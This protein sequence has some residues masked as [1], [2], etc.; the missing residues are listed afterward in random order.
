M[1]SWLGPASGSTSHYTVT[2]THWDEG[3]KV[4]SFTVDASSTRFIDDNVQAGVGYTY[5]V[6]SH[7]RQPVESSGGGDD[8]P[9]GAF[10]PAGTLPGP[11]GNDPPDIQPRCRLLHKHNLWGDRRDQSPR[12]FGQRDGEVT[13]SLKGCD[14]S[15]GD[16]YDS[17]T[18]ENG[19]LVVEANT[20]GH[21]HG[22]N[23]ETAT[24]CMVT[25]S[26]GTE[27]K[28][29]E[30][31]LYIV[32]DRTPPPLPPGA[33]SLVEARS[34]RGRRPSDRAGAFPGVRPAGMEKAG[35]TA[36]L[37]HRPGSYRR[38][39]TDH[40]RPGG[41]DRVRGAGL[42]D[43]HAGLSPLRQQ[44]FGPGQ[45]V[46]R[47]P[48]RRRAGQRRGDNAADGSGPSSPTTSDPGADAA[49]DPGGG[50]PPAADAGTGARA[51]HGHGQRR[52]RHPGNGQ[53]RHRH[54][55]AHAG[56]LNVGYPDSL[57]GHAH[58]GHSHDHAGS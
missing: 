25:G 27:S 37:C 30:F 22:Q 2:R 19:K 11:G 45:Q 8:H 23:T 6:V 54:P 15:S 46:G 43:E 47:Q 12:L 41:S 17:V 26:N 56:Y 13:F 39:D 55:D 48:G 52:V 32:S 51:G 3:P 58:A 53:R 29:Q 16:Y 44:Q 18:V 21:V 50:Y 24:V 40:P 10:S 38:H 1:V 35:R 34:G 57:S 36:H 14:G 31:S 9:D 20:R 49:A 7:G 4:E 33:L 28:D 42:P 5:T